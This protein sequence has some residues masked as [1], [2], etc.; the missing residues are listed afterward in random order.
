MSED[1]EKDT[2]IKALRSQRQRWC[3]DYWKSAAETARLE[4][5]LSVRAE[6]I[7]A[8]VQDIEEQCDEANALGVSFNK[9]TIAYVRRLS[10]RISEAFHGP[11]PVEDTDE[12]LPACEE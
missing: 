11:Q 8:L 1:N 2:T 4:H 10:E 3:D 12:A 6:R 9:H 5:E 7:N